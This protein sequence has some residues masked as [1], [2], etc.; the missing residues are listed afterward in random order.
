MK[1]SEKPLERQVQKT[2]RLH[3]RPGSMTEFPPQ[4][5]HGPVTA[6]LENRTTRED[7]S[8]SPWSRRVKS[9]TDDEQLTVAEL[10]EEANRNLKRLHVH[11]DV[12]ASSVSRREADSCVLSGC[13]WPRDPDGKVYVPYAVANHYFSEE[14]DVIRGAMDSFSNS[15]CILFVP[16]S[17]QKDF[18]HIQ[19]LPGCYSYVGR[20]GGGQL[21]SLSRRGCLHHGTVQHE[22]LHALGFN[23]EH[24]RSDRDQHIRVLLENIMSGHEFNFD[25]VDTRN[26]ETPYDY[27][28]VMHYGRL[29][30]SRDGSS[31]TMEA[32]PDAGAEFGRATRMSRDDVR[33]IK[34][35]YCS[36]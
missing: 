16:R 34:L 32:V 21:V 28:S 15:T 35:L 6:R 3:F 27:S 23:H 9:H 26:Q 13:L 2:Q 29:A 7:V 14:L 12:A 30:F 22:L 8:S 24:R 18:L 19:S 20:R 11:G 36:D 31:P 25:K 33:R 1:E 17:D 10:L 4:L 5:V